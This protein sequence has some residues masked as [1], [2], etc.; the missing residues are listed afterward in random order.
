MIDPKLI[1]NRILQDGEVTL[2]QLEHRATERGVSLSDLYQALNQV[3]RNKAIRRTVRQGEVVYLKALPPKEPGSHLSWVTANYPSM[4][5]TNDGSGIE[6]D[7]SYLFLTPEQLVEYKAAAK[8]M[9][10]FMYNKTH[11]NRN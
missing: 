7:F 1:V 8:N 4:D 6:A 2:S 9:P 10:T 3:H 5:A 11:A